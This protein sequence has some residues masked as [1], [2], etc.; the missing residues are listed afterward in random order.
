[1][2]YLAPSKCRN[3]DVTDSF[4]VAGN[5]V[6]AVLSSLQSND[7]ATASNFAA[8][9]DVL[10]NFGNVSSIN[11]NISTTSNVR[12]NQVNFGANRFIGWDD[13]QAQ[14]LISGGA[15]NNKYLVFKAV[16]PGIRRIGAPVHRGF[17]SD[18]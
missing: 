13:G 18:Y 14:L 7:L 1:M 3:L 2:E 5:D 6:M 11:Q 15:H 10:T 12:F 16:F 9:Q 4:S 17:L 8:K